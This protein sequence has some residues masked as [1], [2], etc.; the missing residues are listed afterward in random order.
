M[1]T[2]ALQKV[3]Q[4]ALK[5]SRIYEQSLLR[6]IARS[7]LASMFIGFGVIVAFKTGSYFYNVQSPMTYPAAAATFGCAIILISYGGGDLFTGNTF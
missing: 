2:E 1:E 6:Y 5:K 3:E 7:M 4:L